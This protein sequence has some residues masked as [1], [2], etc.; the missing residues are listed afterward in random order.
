MKK[1]EPV[2]LNLLI[3][4]NLVF[5]RS[6][7]GEHESITCSQLYDCS[8]WSKD[9]TEIVF[10]PETRYIEVEEDVLIT[11]V[12]NFSITGRSDN[13]QQYVTFVCS[14]L[15]SFIIE[16]SSFIEIR[17]IRIID[18]GKHIS[19]SIFPQ[20]TSTAIFI[21]NVFSIKMV[22]VIIG[23]S[24]GH[25]II[26]LN[27]VGTF[28]LEYMTI[29][30]NSTPPASCER[31]HVL[32]GALL[33]LNLWE[34]DDDS[35]Q[36]DTVI[37]ITQC[38]FFNISSVA[39][40][41][42]PMQDSKDENVTLLPNEYINSSAIGIILHQ[43][44]YQ[45]D[46]K[47]ENINITSFTNIDAPLIFF[48]YSVNSSSNTTIANCSIT[49]TNTSYSTF[50]IS[51]VVE[52]NSTNM[53]SIVSQIRH[54]L[55]ILACRFLNNHAYSIL[56]MAD[57]QKNSM[58]LIFS[59]NIFSKNIVRNVLRTQSV[60][61]VL[62]GST[63]FSS[64][65]ASRIFIVSD[66]LLLTDNAILNFTDN[67]INLQHEINNRYLI[68]KKNPYSLL[69]AIQFTKKA[70]AGIIFNN[71]QGFRRLIYGNPLLG[72]AWISSFRNTHNSLPGEV[73]SKVMNLSNQNIT[74]GISGKENSICQCDNGLT[75][76]LEVKLNPLYPGQSITLSFKHFGFDI[77]MY[78]N[79]TEERFNTTAPTCNISSYD[80][81][82]PKID[83]VFQN[84]TNVSYVITSNSPKNRT[85]LLLL[86]T[87]TKEQ[88]LYAF[89][90]HLRHCPQGFVLDY[91][92]GICK[93]DPNFLLK[94]NGLSCHISTE[95]FGIPPNSWISNDS[96]GVI[97]TNDC[98]F[99]YCHQYPSLVQLSNPDSQCL[100]SR[101]GVAC[102]KCAQGLSVVLGTSR[103]KKCTNY[104][105]FLLPVFAIAGLLL[106]L[107]LFVLNL[108]VV[109][110]DIYGF[111]FM[112]NAL[113]IHKTRV[114][115][116]KQNT[117]WVLIALSNLDLGVEACFYDG[118]TAYAATWLHFMFPIY[119]LLIVVAMAFASRYFQ[120]IEK[121][122][123]KRVIP[124]IATLYLLS[125]N[126]LMV[127]TF[128][129][130]FSYTTIYHLY[131]M[132]TDVYWSTDTG[133][134]LFGVKFTLL[135]IFCLLIFALVIV[136]TN[137]L[138]L[139]SKLSYRYAFIVNYLKPF[140]DAYQ[141][142]F[143]ESCRFFLGTEFILRAIIFACSSFSAQNIGAI[144]N[145]IIVVY[146]A[147]LCQI[148][149]FKSRLNSLIYC[150]YML[151][152]SGFV[153]LF[154]RFFPIQ[155]KAYKLIF[156]LIVYLGIVEFMG[157]I[158]IHVWKYMLCK[159]A[160]FVYLENQLK[161]K[162]KI[163]F[164][165]SRKELDRNHQE[166]LAASYENFQEE[167]LALSPGY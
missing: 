65:E 140:L 44:N 105:L 153:I 40:P 120:V 68:E 74:N 139:F 100:P 7:V 141:A 83:L 103:C 37:T 84:C 165:K 108:T 21:S 131:D 38:E 6:I 98:H 159:F 14:N 49:E 121:I 147:Y 58:E 85:C 20:Q 102:G 18:C 36:E 45:I 134:P 1:P 35:I 60:A 32:F 97:Y 92:E 33:A 127:V 34:G 55:N 87:A 61:P 166:P 56:R 25:G 8:A 31:D 73:Y 77:A 57:I 161:N 146:F 4:I 109:D 42:L 16:N 112:V 79:F 11:N 46:V 107:A 116:S 47:I 86:S 135:F 54:T 117:A 157:I 12:K 156:E 26:G 136:P 5:M 126:K 129:G 50:E 130:L 93:C 132:S 82:T 13:S 69:C 149:P 99:D 17:N 48:S 19:D 91:N 24:C 94:L 155:P 148:K 2:L 160:L 23:N 163:K 150:S 67:K 80:L 95:S 70:D 123:R 81:S 9:Y 158:M 106:V 90:V 22:N 162:C 143:R 144:Y 151:Y 3:L 115:P 39:H 128:R 75:N 28:T 125:Y 66:Y 154:M 59:D 52:P 62:Y 78:T 64:N 164:F 138:F 101:S 29:Y 137:V 114:F 43:M 63:E 122:T 152:T 27:V 51:F 119:V 113:S 41:S 142:P 124:V 76:C 89:R 71:N 96:K 167:L 118:M 72:C 88:T 133:I 10:I 110:G 15:S 145:T 30:G 104:W 111:I 53:S